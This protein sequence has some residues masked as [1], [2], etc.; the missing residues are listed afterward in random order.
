M[1]YLMFHNFITMGTRGC[2]VLDEFTGQFFFFLTKIYRIVKVLFYNN[3][4]ATKQLSSVTMLRTTLRF[5]DQK[6]LLTIY[7]VMIWEQMIYIYIYI[8]IKHYYTLSKKHQI[9]YGSII[10]TFITIYPELALTMHSGHW[11]S[12]VTFRKHLDSHESRGIAVLLALKDLNPNF[13][14]HF[15]CF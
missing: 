2:S 14:K 12:Y 6:Q 1:I 5:M 10:Q 4:L 3:V 9:S 11:I 8:Y 7:F 15:H 13:P